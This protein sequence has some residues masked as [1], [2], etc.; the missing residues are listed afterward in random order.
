MNLSDFV[1][2][3]FVNGG[4]GFNG[5]DCWGLVMLYYKHFLESDLPDYHINASDFDEISRTMHEATETTE[6]VWDIL[7]GPEPNAIVLMR[8]GYSRDINHAGVILDNGKML[9]C[10]ESTG[11][12]IVDPTSPVWA[13]LIRMYIKPSEIKIK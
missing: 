12:C 5:C 10:Y 2:I 7:N 1:G 9:H 6:G 8:L 4:R 13:K 11:S 3:P